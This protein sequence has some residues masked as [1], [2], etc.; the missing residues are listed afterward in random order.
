MCYVKITEPW[1]DG[2][3]THVPRE[4]D[5]RPAKEEL[6]GPFSGSV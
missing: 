6:L 4:I 3:S 5:V 1:E 2:E